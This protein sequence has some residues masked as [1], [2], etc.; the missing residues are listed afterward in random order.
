MIDFNIVISKLWGVCRT[1]SCDPRCGLDIIWR[2]SN[3]VVSKLWGVWCTQ[4]YD[5]PCGVEITWGPKINKIELNCLIAYSFLSILDVVGSSRSKLPFLSAAGP[6]SPFSLL[7]SCAPLASGS[8][9]EQVFASARFLH[10]FRCGGPARRSAARLCARFPLFSLRQRHP[11][12]RTIGLL[13]ILLVVLVS[14]WGLS[15]CIRP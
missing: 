2:M 15:V 11:R 3:T 10:P 4:S 12:V 7:G 13:S 8:R 6:S 14:A 5:P 9:R 1:Q